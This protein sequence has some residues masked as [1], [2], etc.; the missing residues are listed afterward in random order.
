M[1]IRLPINTSTMQAHIFLP[2]VI[3]LSTSCLRVAQNYN[4][5]TTA[6]VGLEVGLKEAIGL[7]SMFQVTGAG[8]GSGADAGG[9]TRLAAGLEGGTGNC[10]GGAGAGGED[11]AAAG[12]AREQPQEQQYEMALRSCLGALRKMQSFNTLA[13]SHVS[14]LESGNFSADYLGRL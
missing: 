5:Q 1:D 10:G 9:G 4:L 2:S 11:R 8:A 3:Y 7:T 13:R 14:M 6:E 12:V